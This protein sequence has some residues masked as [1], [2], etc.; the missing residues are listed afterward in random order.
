MS[1]RKGI[2]LA[3]GAG[4]RLHPLTLVTS[5]QLLPVYNKPMIY[6][7]LSLLMLA[8][9]REVLIISTP[10]DLPQFRQILKDGSQWG[11]KFEYA[12]QPKPEGLAQAF[13]IGEEFLAGNPACLVLGDN[14]FYGNSI[15]GLLENANKQQSGATVFGYPVRDP[16]RYGVVEF[17]ESWNVLSIE[18]KPQK[19]KSNYAVPGLYF[20]DENVVELAR[21]VQP[22]ARGEYEITTLN[23]MYLEQGKL[24]VQIVGRGIAWFDTGTHGSLLQAANFVEAI[25][26]RQGLMI[27]CPEEIAC[28]NEWI[29]RDD[30]LRIASEFGKSSYAEYL[31]GVATARE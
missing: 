27:A 9:I 31:H 12:E 19:P 18:E 30:V 1:T 24:K 14:I 15:S 25:E 3:G 7:P 10:H 5:K 17:D 11:M 16:E 28:L 2:I 23:Q 8:K 4:T 13:W 21:Q 29:N 6:Y 22:S 26:E 20:Y